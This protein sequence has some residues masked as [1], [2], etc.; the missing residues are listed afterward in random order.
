MLSYWYKPLQ[1]NND[2]I[3]KNE[4]VAKCLLKWVKSAKHLKNTQKSTSTINSKIMIG[5]KH[6]VGN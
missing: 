4:N 5:K 6:N 3:I 2:P 1:Q